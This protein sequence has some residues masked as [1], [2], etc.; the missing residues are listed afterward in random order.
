MVYYED[1]KLIIRNMDNSM[2][3]PSDK[4]GWIKHAVFTHITDKL[5]WLDI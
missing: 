4:P 2:Y 3:I 5:N 1:E